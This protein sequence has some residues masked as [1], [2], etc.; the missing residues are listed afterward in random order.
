MKAIALD[1]LD[2]QLRDKMLAAIMEPVLITEHDHPVLVIRNLLEDDTAD[3]LIA[4]HPAFQ[5]TIRR[6]RQQKME[7]R[8]R[9]L[10]DLRQEYD[11]GAK[12]QG[13][14]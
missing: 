10:A 2:A 9:R 11:A 6:A 8:V 4:Q 1:E 14:N 5:E 3:E 13:S 7:G 12:A